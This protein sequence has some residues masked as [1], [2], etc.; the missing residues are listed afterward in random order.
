MSHWQRLTCRFFA[1]ALSTVLL[2]ACS[3]VGSTSSGP[4]TEPIAPAR[5]TLD[6]N[7]DVPAGSVS[8]RSPEE[9]DRIATGVVE[10]ALDAIGTPYQWG[11]TDAN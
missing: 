6:P 8:V 5:P 7:D 11:G 2:G 3:V 4:P 9:T 10:L 1:L